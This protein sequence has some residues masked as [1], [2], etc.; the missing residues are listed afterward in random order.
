MGESSEG[1]TQGLSGERMKQEI[2]QAASKCR[3]SEGLIVWKPAIIHPGR[4]R[5]ESRAFGRE[6]GRDIEVTSLK[7][8]GQISPTWRSGQGM[9]SKRGE[10]CDQFPTISCL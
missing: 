8:L 9:K 4:L 2:A 1:N 3:Q 7:A 6:V 5:A 10:A